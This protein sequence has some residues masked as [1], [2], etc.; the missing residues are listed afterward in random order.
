MCD[1][2]TWT[3]QGY[4]SHCLKGLHEDQVF[5]YD[6]MTLVDAFVFNFP[7]MGSGTGNHDPLNF[8]MTLYHL[9]RI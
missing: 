2:L 9:K 6:A 3:E 1:R 5:G 7:L 4:S 8:S